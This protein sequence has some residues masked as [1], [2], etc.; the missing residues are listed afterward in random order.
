MAEKQEG[1]LPWVLK[2]LN[3][4][5]DLPTNAK[6]YIESVIEGNRDPITGDNF[7]K[8]E[9]AIIRDL[10][11]ESNSTLPRK[12]LKT[13]P[14]T[15]GKVDYRT[16]GKD[17][18]NAHTTFGIRSNRSGAEGIASIFTPEGRVG[19][20][21][22]QFGYNVNPEGDVEVLDT[23]DFNAYQNGRPTHGAM[24]RDMNFFGK[25]LMNLV[26]AGYA[27][28]R[29]YGQEHLDAADDKGR[30]VKITI[31]KED[32]TEEEYNRIYKEAAKEFNKG[33][34]VKMPTNYSK[35]NWNLI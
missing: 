8:E 28:L 3:N 19:T 21:L 23:Y 20:T 25:G 31:P 15:P 18:K 22:G 14:S 11:V 9:I 7:T 29:G 10:I 17:L 24:Y 26:T 35:G 16:Y 33:G 4:N 5:F 1:F 34:K 27:G 2:K 32:F 13:L 6:V 12:N 30:P